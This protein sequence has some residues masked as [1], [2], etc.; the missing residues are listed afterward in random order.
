MQSPATPRTDGF[1]PK[2]HHFHPNDRVWLRNPFDHD[3]VFQVADEYNN[4]FKYRLPRGKVSELPGGAIATLGVK[5][6]VDELIQNSEQDNLL[7]WDER[8]RA[9]HEK[10]IIVQVRSMSPR[11]DANRPGEINLGSSTDDMPQEEEDVPAPPEEA[12]PGLNDSV[13]P[14]PA[15]QS[16]APSLPPTAA[17]GIDDVVAASLPTS[18][19]VVES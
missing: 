4:P 15:E 3:V 11:V 2:Y 10:A 14:E 17:A 6:I 16:H 7:M 1:K 9:K 5:A 8:I 18:N 19:A 13:Q 12:F